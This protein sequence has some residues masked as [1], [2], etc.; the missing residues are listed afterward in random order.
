MATDHIS[1]RSNYFGVKDPEAF[2]AW[3]ASVPG[4]KHEEHMGAYAIRTEPG[5]GGWPN[6]LAL[7]E[8]D[9]DDEEKVLANYKDLHDVLASHLLE[10]EVAILSEAGYCA[11]RDQV[12]GHYTAVAWDGRTVGIGLVDL[13]V[14]IKEVFGSV[15][16]LNNPAKPLNMP[17]PLAFVEHADDGE[18]LAGPVVNGE[19]LWAKKCATCPREWVSRA[20]AEVLPI[21]IRYEDLM[22]HR[23]TG[24]A[25]T[26]A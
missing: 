8:Y 12:Y 3:V 17:N 21:R 13:A 2:L 5:T 1:A 7:L 25:P 22:A 20:D 14:R 9:E 11:E 26:K 24:R 4:L 16:F 19:R 6:L 23:K 18:R 10:G 15:Q